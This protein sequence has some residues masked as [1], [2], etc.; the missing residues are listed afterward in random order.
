VTGHQAVVIRQEWLK[1]QASQV[2]AL[3]A[4]FTHVKCSGQQ[5]V[6]AV[7]TAVLTEQSITFD[8]LETKER[9]NIEQ[10]IRQIAKTLGAEVFVT[11]DA[12]SL[13]NVADDLG[14]THQICRALVNRNVHT[15]IG[16]LGT[17]VMEHPVRVSWELDPTQISLD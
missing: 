15:L 1:C 2:Q 7:A 16:E 12:D 6:V 17:Q 9:S 5:S 10:C 14:L 11:D 13:K 4:D 8:L 3:S